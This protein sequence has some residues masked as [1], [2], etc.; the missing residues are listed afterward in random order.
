MSVSFSKSSIK[1][2]FMLTLNIIVI[3]LTILLINN[4]SFNNANQTIK[5]EKF[6][7]IA[8]ADLGYFL[9]ALNHI[10]NIVKLDPKLFIAE[11]DLSYKKSYH[12]WFNTN[13]I[14]NSKTKIYYL[15]IIEYCKYLIIYS[16]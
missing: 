4:N 9:R 13:L 3:F 5:N 16:I 10:K 14:L 6:N 1:L 7:I 15:T 8:F 2:Q 11:G 12:H